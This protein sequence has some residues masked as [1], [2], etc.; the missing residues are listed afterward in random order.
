MLLLMGAMSAWAQDV[1]V[2]KDGST[3]VCRVVE[4]TNTEVTYKKWNDLQGSNY[5]INQKDLMAINYENGTK[6]TFDE[7]TVAVETAPFPTVSTKP[8][9][10]DELLKLD[11]MQST[12]QVDA[13]QLALKTEKKIKRLKIVGWIVGGVCLGAG[14]T[15]IATGV[16]K[17]TRSGDSSPKVFRPQ[18]AEVAMI[19]SGVVLAAGGIATTTGC[20]IKAHKLQTQL[21]TSSQYSVHS[22][23][24]YQQEFHMKNGATLA[25]G[26]DLLGDNTN[27]HH[28]FGIGLNYNF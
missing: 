2:K 13:L 21:Q 11:A 24:L 18:Q 15:L 12:P 27:R 22:A 10:D 8:M 25:T 23:P 16:N 6:K 17:A 7:N 5:I 4:V 1:I 26:I 3:L 19:S 14:V 9:T 20:L 28:T